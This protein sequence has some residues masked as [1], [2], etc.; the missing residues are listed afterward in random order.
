MKCDT[1]NKNIVRTKPGLV[2]GRCEK[3]VHHTTSCAGLTNKQL[4]ALRATENL[5]WTCQE[6][7]D[8]SPRRR[9]IIV[10]DDEEEDE[11]RYDIPTDNLQIDVK[12]LLKDITQHVEKTIRRE[13]K[14]I[15]HSLQ[16]H[17][18]LMQDSIDSVN[19]M[20]TIMLDLKKKNVE[21]VNKNKHLET[22]VGALEQRIQDFEQQ[23][24][25]RNLEI[26]YMPNFKDENT[27]QIA[28]TLAK[29][30][31]LRTSDIEHAQRMHGKKDNP[32]PVQIILKTEQAQEQWLETFKQ[33]Q[34]SK[35]QIKLSD[36]FGLDNTNKID[37][38][39]NIVIREALTPYN[40]HL[41]W[42]AKQ[43]IRDTYKYIWIKKGVLRV[44]KDGEENKPI[45]VRSETD[46]KNLK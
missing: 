30:L 42:Y 16:T 6:C 41:L 18:D 39:Q 32:G 45:I 40:K 27:L 4:T 34:K 24:L 28:Q 7:H 19:E 46:I 31:N 17:S 22:R 23:K 3:I 37:H 1:C 8:V 11:I 5:E 13:L 9:S 10:P 15:N 20:K 21:L 36:I 14:D 33:H 29:K 44:R 25:S 35:G 38:D 26:H 2:C 12:Q 43:E